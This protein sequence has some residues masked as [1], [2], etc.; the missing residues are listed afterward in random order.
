VRGALIDGAPTR[1]DREWQPTLQ[2]ALLVAVAL[3]LTGIAVG[4][5]WVRLANTHAD[6]GPILSVLLLNDPARFDGDIVATY[7]GA[8]ARATIQNWLPAIAA[9]WAGVSPERFAIVLTYAQNVLPPVAMFFF[10]RAI[11]LGGLR[12]MIAAAIVLALDPFSWNLANY[13]SLTTVPYAGTLVVTP[14]LL[15]FTASARDRRLRCMASLLLTALV[16]PSIGV[17]ATLVV[18]VDRLMRQRDGVGGEDRRGATAWLGALVVPLMAA[19]IPPLVLRAGADALAPGQLFEGMARN[20]HMH[21]WATQP[22]WSR[23][24]L[25]LL[26]VAALA[27]YAVRCRMAPPRARRLWLA[28]IAVAVALALIHVIAWHARIALVVQLIPMRATLCFAFVSV[29]LI[30]AT[31]LDGLAAVGASLATRT[32]TLLAVLMLE[33]YGSGL[34]LGLIPLVTDRRRRTSRIVM[35]G[36]L[37]LTVVAV[38]AAWVTRVS[39]PGTVGAY[40]AASVSL[41]VVLA[42]A[43]GAWLRRRAAA[44]RHRRRASAVL[45]LGL[46]VAVAGLKARSQGRTAS[47]PLARANLD[48]QRWARRHTAD[49]AIFIVRDVPWRT[50]S[51]RRAVTPRAARLYVYSASAATKA[52][53]DAYL[54]FF[55]LRE[56]APALD[57]DS[58]ERLQR[59]AFQRLTATDI[60][61]LAERFGGD[62]VVRL[63]AEPVAL[64]IAYANDALLVYAIPTSRPV[65]GRTP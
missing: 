1:Q 9:R 46:L 14:M 63:R 4:D 42:L 22:L 30:A 21:P 65:K 64:P 51:R 43:L 52:F 55:G 60:G 57:A 28:S 29:P 2:V 12:A 19:I 18:A 31:L 11:G 17:Y 24:L 6:D 5:V 47:E 7:A 3:A 54:D 10:A 13:V 36:L 37:A 62:Y 38:P 16:H 8:A 35:T 20:I 15:A 44:L 33:I 25:T 32:A 53:D 34:A 58:L 27:T 23:E 49:D 45:L 41:S 26:A 61:R 50:I 56:E 39:A 48:A 59:I 40:A